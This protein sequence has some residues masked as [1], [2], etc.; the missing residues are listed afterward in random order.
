M[1]LIINKNCTGGSLKIY[2]FAFKE[3]LSKKKLFAEAYLEG[4]LIVIEKFAP[5]DINLDILN[6]SY[7]LSKTTSTPKK[8]FAKDFAR[9]LS[10]DKALQKRIL[11]EFQKTE[12]I[13]FR[14]FTKLLSSNID[15]GK[16]KFQNASTWRSQPTLNEGYHLDIYKATSLRAY[17]NLSPK[18]RSWGIGHRACDLIKLLPENKKPKAIKIAEEFKNNEGLFQ[19]KINSYFNKE[20]LDNLEQHNIQ[21]EQYDLW[22]CDGLKACHQIISG[23][24]MAG[25]DYPARAADTNSNDLAELRN[26]SN[27]LTKNL[28]ICEQTLASE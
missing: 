5:F 25:F 20:I 10:Q 26:Y 22:I 6:Q 15:L 12:Q 4:H 23:D 28:N 27:W 8:P 16:L 17:W 18:P 19:F 13:V 3:L 9:S 14:L 1:K 11:E 21:F 7:E 24:M 2:K